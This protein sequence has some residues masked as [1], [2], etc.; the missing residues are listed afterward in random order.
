MNNYI[1][2]EQLLNILKNVINQGSFAGVSYLQLK[3]LEQQLSGLPPFSSNGNP[4]L[5]NDANQKPEAQVKK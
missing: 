4:N 2:S 5:K 3:S 1:I